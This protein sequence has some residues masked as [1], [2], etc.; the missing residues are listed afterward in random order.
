MS[1]SSFRSCFSVW[2]SDLWLSEETFPERPC[3]PPSGAVPDV[4]STPHL[5][6]KPQLLFAGNHG[7]TSFCVAE[8]M[9]KCWP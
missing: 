6:E 8:Q 7:N 2:M 9:D 3:P 1:S 4:S 5:L